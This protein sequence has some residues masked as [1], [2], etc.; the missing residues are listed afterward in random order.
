MNSGR[1][2]SRHPTACQGAF[3]YI[4]VRFSSKSTLQACDYEYIERV[5]SPF[6]RRIAAL[7]CEFLIVNAAAQAPERGKTQTVTLGIISK[8]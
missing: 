7:V 6:C 5:N 4:R 1:G 2:Q 8:I 3:T